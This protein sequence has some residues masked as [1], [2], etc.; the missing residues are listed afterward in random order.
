[1]T[2]SNIFDRDNLEE[3]IP[4]VWG[5]RI[6]DYFK[7][8]MVA[9]S[10][11]TDRSDELSGGGDILYTPVI[12]AMTVNTK[13]AQSEVTLQAADQ[14]KVTLTVQTHKEVSFLIEGY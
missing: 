2:A 8:T 5:Q 9:G 1:M 12:K 14:D 11:F 4:A 10:F 3:L 13:N 7:A 6:N